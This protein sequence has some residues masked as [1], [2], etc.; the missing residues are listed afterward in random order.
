MLVD[1]QPV[2]EDRLPMTS[3]GLLTIHETFDLGIIACRLPQTRRAR[4]SP[5]QWQDSARRHQ[6]GLKSAPERDTWGL[7]VNAYYR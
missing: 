3:A 1:E 2:D 6:S 7:L 5:C 4:V